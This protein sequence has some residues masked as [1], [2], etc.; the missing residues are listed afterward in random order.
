MSGSLP[1][2]PLA[3][4][5]AMSLG[6]V[7]PS[8]VTRLKLRSVA[9]LNVFCRHLFS[10]AASVVRKASIVPMFGW[11]MP[12]P[13]AVPPTV[14]VLPP[15][16]TRTAASLVRVSVVRMASA[17]PAPSRPRPAATPSIPAEIFAIGRCSP[18]TPVEA[19]ATSSSLY[20]QSLGRER[21]HLAGVLQPLL[22]GPGIGVPAVGNYHP[23]VS[24]FDG[25]PCNTERRAF[26]GVAR[27]DGRRRTLVLGEEEAEIPPPSVPYPA[28]DPSSDESFR[29]RYSPRERLYADCCIFIHHRSELSHW[30]TRCSSGL[31]K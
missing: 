12:L 26:D 4:S 2:A 19:T 18:I 15:T 30:Y 5:T 22:P 20:S 14:T 8:T 3:S 16:S 10:T 25:L 11:I 28:H 27:E 17:K 1:A 21:L 31:F 9:T 24:A 6:E 13:L 23:H 7:S 29:R